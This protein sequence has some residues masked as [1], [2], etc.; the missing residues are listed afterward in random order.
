MLSFD[1]YILVIV[2][3]AGTF[4]LICVRCNGNEQISY[5]SSAHQQEIEESEG[6]CALG[7]N[8][9]NVSGAHQLSIELLK[10]V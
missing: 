4:I 8:E 6:E 7:N 1:E 9:S 5:Q 10:C 2:S 3:A